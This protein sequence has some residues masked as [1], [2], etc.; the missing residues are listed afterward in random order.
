LKKQFQKEQ[1]EWDK[2]VKEGT[3][4]VEEGGDVGDGDVKE[5]TVAKEEEEE[6]QV[7]KESEEG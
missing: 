7:K 6:V 5:E 1:K 4:K 3:V 2:A